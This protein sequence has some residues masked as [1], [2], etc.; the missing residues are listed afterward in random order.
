MSQAAEVLQ[1]KKGKA[2]KGACE[3]VEDEEDEH[4]CHSAGWSRELWID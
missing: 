4:L 2:L 3:K 1:G